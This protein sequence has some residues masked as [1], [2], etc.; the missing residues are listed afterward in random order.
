MSILDATI[1][2][3]D[4]TPATLRD[5]TGG[6]PALL[7]NV[8]S[9]CG[10][11]PQYTG[12]EQLHEKYADRGF[13]VVGLPCNQFGGQEPGSSEEIAEFCSAT[14]GVTF[15]MTREDRG[16]RRGPPRGLR[17]LVETP[18]EKGQAGDI[19]WNFEKFLV[20]ADGG[21]V[22]RFSP[23][24]EP[25]DAR[26]VGGSSRCSA[27]VDVAALL[28]DE[29]VVDGHN[30]CCGPPGPDVYDWGRLDVGAG[31]TPRTPT[32]PAARRRGGRAV[33]V[34][35][36]PDRLR[37]TR[38][39][40]T[41]EQVDATFALTER[42]A[43]WLVLA[44][45]VDESR[46]ETLGRIASLLGVECGKGIDCSLGTLR[47]LH[48]LGVRY[49]TLTVNATPREPTPPPTAVAC[50]RPIVREMNGS[51]MVDSPRLRRHHARR[52]AVA[53]GDG[54][55][56][57]SSARAVTSRARRTTRWRRC[58]T[59]RGLHGDVRA[60][61]VNQACA[62][63]HRECRRCRGRTRHR[64]DR[65]RALRRPGTP[66]T[67][68]PTGAASPTCSTWSAHCEHVRGVAGQRHVGLG[69]DDDGWRC[70]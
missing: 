4:G 42:Y 8:A 11:T 3:L 57:L 2:R 1:A 41:L 47:P 18:D 20:D 23:R 68:R 64:R 25:D 6:R 46:R 62:D 14:Y 37:V 70:C 24:V 38:A 59:G 35:R 10:L 66:P 31:G 19:A 17:R 29:T 55:L 50:L 39:E 15:P 44:R 5:L 54:D 28:V 33:L 32:S 52:L 53:R 45:T 9:K 60:K 63:W 43:D 7:V 58:A 13:T 48:A 49:L 61:F 40:R 34:G 56:T 27:D 30:D 67:A 21:V 51:T 12:L 36:R 16:Q 69:S 26:L 65:R 22:A